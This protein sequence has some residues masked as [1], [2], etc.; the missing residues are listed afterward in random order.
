MGR[1]RVGR[2][3]SSFPEVAQQQSLLAEGE[4]C[5]AVSPSVGFLTGY[6]CCLPQWPAILV[7]STGQTTVDHHG[8][9]F[10]VNANSFYLSSLLLVISCHLGMP[11]SPVILL[12]G[13]LFLFN[14][15]SLLYCYRFFNV[16]LSSLQAILDCEY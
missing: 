15:C 11:I 7:S 16:T 6:G 13:I 4:K 3:S 5:A 2:N 8:S 1:H 12:M 10:I 14:F 9:F